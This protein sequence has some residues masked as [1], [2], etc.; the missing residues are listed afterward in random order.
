M[1]ENI[2]LNSHIDFLINQIVAC[3]CLPNLKRKYSYAL[4]SIRS[5]SQAGCITRQ[6][7][8]YYMK[9]ARDLRNNKHHKLMKPFFDNLE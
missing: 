5:L 2:V 6:Q 8:F 1:K 9:L 3:D 7:Y 4:G